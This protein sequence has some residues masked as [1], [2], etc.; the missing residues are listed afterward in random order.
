MLEQE[1][2]E[3][4][5]A[6]FVNP[7]KKL[8]IDLLR[9]RYESDDNGNITSLS[10]DD[11]LTEKMKR[12][13]RDA[14]ERAKSGTHG[15]TRDLATDMVQEL[16][17]E[18]VVRKMIHIVFRIGSGCLNA[19]EQYCSHRKMII[20]DTIKQVFEKTHQQMFNSQNILEGSFLKN[21]NSNLNNLNLSKSKKLKI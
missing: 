14:V 18:D 1:K 13:K 4:N 9:Y 10:I 11:P 7:F 16:Y 15:I 21:S 19:I 20:D 12:L 17:S 6:P 5:D 2:Q 8:T 3:K